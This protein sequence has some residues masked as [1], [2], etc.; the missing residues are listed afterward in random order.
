MGNRLPSWANRLLCGL[1]LGL[2]GGAPAVG[3]G[4]GLVP[5]TP[6]DTVNVRQS[7]R[8][9]VFQ[10]DIRNSILNRRFVTIPGIKLGVEWRGRL[11]TGVGVYFLSN[12]I[13]SRQPVPSE[14]PAGTTTT[15]RLRYVAGYGEYVLIGNPRWEVNG[16]LQLGVGKTYAAYTLPNDE[17]MYSRRKTIWLVEPS[18]AAQLRI[19]RWLALGTGVGW[20]QP[21]FVSA[22]TQRELNGPVFYGR[23]KLSLGDVYKIFRGRERLF[24]QKG[25]RRADW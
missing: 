12:P 13:P 10:L 17:M 18:M 19:Y 22:L 16:Q 9:A 15:L 6:H 5:T 3:G 4:I 1:G 21:V 2:V 8:R 7:H 20:R 11:R 14:L 23:V 25:L 24:S